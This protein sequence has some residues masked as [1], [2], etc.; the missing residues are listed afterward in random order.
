MA[1]YSDDMRIA[2]CPNDKEG[3]EKRPDFTGNLEISGTKYRVSLWKRQSKAGKPFL[4]GEISQDQPQ[5][6]T[7][8]TQQEA[9]GGANLNDDIP[10]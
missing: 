9:S 2:V 7:Y 10:F 5:N 1:E 3:N 6:N 4:S 8:G